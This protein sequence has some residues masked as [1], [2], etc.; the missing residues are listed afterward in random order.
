MF[1]VRSAKW[2][3]KCEVST[4]WN[5]HDEQQVFLSLSLLWGFNEHVLYLDNYTM[6][7]FAFLRID[8]FVFF[9][10]YCLRYSP[11]KLYISSIK[12]LLLYSVWCSLSLSDNLF[13]LARRIK[14][15]VIWAKPFGCYKLLNK[16]IF[17]SLA[18]A[19]YIF[20]FRFA[21][22]WQ[23]TETYSPQTFSVTAAVVAPAVAICLNSLLLLEQ[24]SFRWGQFLKWC[25][26]W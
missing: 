4:K 5:I 26:S 3:P 18:H 20:V 7:F 2:V 8:Y 19:F 13:V 12:L 17:N 11:M 16:E 24:T 9:T 21:K 14:P 1:E 23:T 15:F 6:L 25:C 10:W 22:I